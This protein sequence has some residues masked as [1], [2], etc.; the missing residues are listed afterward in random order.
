MS[1]PDERAGG[2]PAITSFFHA[3]RHRRRVP[4]CGR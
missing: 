1:G 3:G 4:E 2:N